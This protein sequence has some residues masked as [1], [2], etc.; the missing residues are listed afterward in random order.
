ML[1]LLYEYTRKTDDFA[2]VRQ[3]YGR[4]T[5]SSSNQNKLIRVVVVV[6]VVV[7]LVVVGGGDFVVSKPKAKLNLS[8][9]L[10]N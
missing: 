5:F 8:T 9:Y 4:S 6:V 10:M 2:G 3:K 7:V 1:K